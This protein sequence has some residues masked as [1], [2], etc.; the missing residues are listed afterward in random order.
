M[1]VVLR[2]KDYKEPKDFVFFKSPNAQHN[3]T[4]W[5]A[6][7]PNAMKLDLNHYRSETTIWAI[8]LH[9]RRSRSSLEHGLAFIRS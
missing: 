1:L 3:E 9:S 6:R 7:L 8:E 4:A 2:A 5:A